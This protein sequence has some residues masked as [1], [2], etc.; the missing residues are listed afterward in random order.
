M[1]T[2]T[3]G[4]T[5]P[6][7]EHTWQQVDLAWAAHSSSAATLTRLES[8]PEGL[9]SREAS[10]RLQLVGPNGIEGRGVHAVAILGRQLKNPLLLLLGVTA[11]AAYLFGDRNDALIILAISCLSVGLGFFNE[12]RSERAVV[13]LHARIRQHAVVVRDGRA[14]SIDVTELVPGD[15]VQLDVGDVVPADLRLLEVHELECDEGVL[16]GEAMTAAKTVAPSPA[17]ESPLKLPSCAFMG[18]L[19]RGGTA[20]AVVVRTGA[21]TAFGRIAQQLSRQQPVTAFQR[22]LQGFSMLLV[23]VTA[24]LCV[25]IFVLNALLGRPLIQSALFALSIAVGLTAP[26]AARDRDRQPLLWRPAAGQEAG[27]G[28]APDQH[29]RPGQRGGSLQ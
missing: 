26:I 5:A 24:V 28:Q 20:T 16:T 8:S 19:V 3:A 21:G 23:R 6:N 10:R 12:Y 25:S 22:G 27:A 2:A 15:I 13:A 14:K 11:L 9:S 18:T 17:S 29:R 7:L 4:R 1:A